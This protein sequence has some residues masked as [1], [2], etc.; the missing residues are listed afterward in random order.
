[1]AEAE[2]K[3][4]ERKIKKWWLGNLPK[5]HEKYHPSRLSWQ[6]NGKESTSSAGETGLIPGLG[7]SP[8]EGNGSPSQHSCLE[9]PM[10]RGACL[11]GSK[12]LGSQRV[13]HNLATK[14]QRNYPS[15]PR[16]LT[17]PTRKAQNTQR[18]ILIKLLR[19]KVLRAIRKS[20]VL[21]EKTAGFMG[22]W[23]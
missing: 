4:R 18:H 14:Q 5:F 8:G 2:E 13:R 12:S 17:N 20:H 11:G 23:F 19:D 3:R 6:L 15:N 21:W 10:D 1:M 7:R 9:N 16:N 22:G